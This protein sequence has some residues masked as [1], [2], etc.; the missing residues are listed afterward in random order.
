[1]AI[2]GPTLITTSAA[3]ADAAT[4][5]QLPSFAPVPPSSFGPPLNSGGYYVGQ[6]HDNLYWVTGGFYQSMFLTGTRGVVVVDAPPTI[7]FHA[8]HIGASS[9][10]TAPE[11]LEIDG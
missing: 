4:G 5:D 9:I 10:W 1:M 3:T 8:D 6:I 11:S 7:D 2:L